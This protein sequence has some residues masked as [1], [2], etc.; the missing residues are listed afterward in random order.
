MTGIFDWFTSGR[1]TCDQACHLARKSKGGEDRW[2]PVGSAILAPYDARV[3]FG[4]YND[5]ASSVRTTY[6]N[7]FAHEAIHYGKST[8]KVPH[9]VHVAAGTL[10]ATSDGRKGVWG[11]GGS[12]GEHIHF[13]GIDPR[14]NRIR[15]QD[16][17]PPAGALAGI[18]AIPLTPT[19]EQE[20]ET[21]MRLINVTEGKGV[22]FVAPGI[23]PVHVKNQGHLKLL[24]RL[25]ENT[26]TLDGRETFNPA[27]RDI[28]GAYLQGIQP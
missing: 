18:T 3:T 9:G 20:E 28:L 11:A 21:G 26:K 5:G 27:E 2:H 1:V 8:E 15:W 12:D 14:G 23:K 19:P 22:W 6:T 17:P 4:M 16:V 25:I 10:L 7:G 13:H 24:A